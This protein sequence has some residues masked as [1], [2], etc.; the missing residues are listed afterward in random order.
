MGTVRHHETNE[1]RVIS[2]AAFVFLWISFH[3]ELSLKSFWLGRRPTEHRRRLSRL[4][5]V[6]DGF[7]HQVV[8]VNL[9]VSHI[10]LS[11]LF[12]QILIFNR[13]TNWICL[14]PPPNSW[15]RYLNTFTDVF[16]LLTDWHFV[17]ETKYFNRLVSH[18][19]LIRIS[20][21][22]WID[23]VPAI[24]NFEINLFADANIDAR[25]LCVY[26]KNKYFSRL[27]SHGIFF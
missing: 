20:S 18:G 15:R 12:V 22:F 13:L 27:L 6:T 9:P 10:P 17:G 26:L 25:W 1:V 5:H 2:R 3:F 8:C 24:I 23:W 16:K 14:P 4:V 7:E 11:A 21:K 19:N